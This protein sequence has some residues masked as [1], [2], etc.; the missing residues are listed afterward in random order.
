MYPSW[1]LVHHWTFQGRLPEVP[2]LETTQPGNNLVGSAILVISRNGWYTDETVE[3]EREGG[4]RGKGG[5]SEEREREEGQ[6]MTHTRE[7]TREPVF[8]RIP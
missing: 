3:G 1:S 7:E 2:A 8:H 4:R 6:T 5:A